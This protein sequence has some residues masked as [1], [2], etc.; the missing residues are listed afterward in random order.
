[1]LVFREFCAWM[2]EIAP[3]HTWLGEL[4]D[5]SGTVLVQDGACE[6]SRVLEDC[7][8]AESRIARFCVGMIIS[9]SSLSIILA[10][11]IAAAMSSDENSLKALRCS[12]EDVGARSDIPWKAVR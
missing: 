10:S 5:T 6:R 3:A 1:M 7:G 9:R 11:D 12:P 2:R 8:G 4:G